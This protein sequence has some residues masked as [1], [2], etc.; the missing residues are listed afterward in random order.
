MRNPSFGLIWFRIHTYSHENTL[1]MYL[2]TCVSLLLTRPSRSINLPRHIL[3]MHANTQKSRLHLLRLH[4]GGFLLRAFFLPSPSLSPHTHTHGFTPPQGESMEQ[5]LKDTPH[6]N[7]LA[8][9]L[10]SNCHDILGTAEPDDTSSRVGDPP[11]VIAVTDSD[12]PPHAVASTSGVTNATDAVHVVPRLI[13]KTWTERQF[14]DYGVTRSEAEALLD[15][16]GVDGT[17]VIRAS[18]F[19]DITGRPRCDSTVGYSVSCHH[20]GRTHHSRVLIF[21]GN[22]TLGNDGF[23]NLAQLVRH[24]QGVPLPCGQRLRYPVTR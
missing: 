23:S 11:G 8:E 21:E 18:Y 10:I 20:A 6:S 1:E 7:S 4:L 12:A 16:I 19:P 9:F 17:F 3:W 13:P 24:Y 2:R 15:E 22:M 14:L 5:M